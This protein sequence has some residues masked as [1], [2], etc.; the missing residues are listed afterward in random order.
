MKT[1]RVTTNGRVTI[2][3]ELRKKHG[4]YPGRKVRFWHS[5]SFGRNAEDGI[6][7]IP[8]AT[9]EEIRTFA[10]SLGLKGKMLRSLMKEKKRERGV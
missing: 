8:L 7:M 2:P 9:V 6:R 5:H 3:A 1:A 10:G 4:F